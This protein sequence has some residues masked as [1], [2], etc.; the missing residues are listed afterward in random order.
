MLL[1]WWSLVAG[2]AATLLLIFFA[3]AGAGIAV[4]SD[5]R[6]VMGGV[7]PV[8]A[9][10]GVLLLIAD[11]FLPVPSSLIMA[12]NGALFGFGA[13]AALSMTGSVGSA[14]AAFAV[15]R[16]GN[17]AIRRFVTPRE[18]ERAGALLARWGL[19]AIALTRPV[20][21]LAETVAILAGSSPVTWRQ[22]TLAAAAGSVVPAAAYAWAGAYARDAVSPAVVFLGVLAVTAVMALAARLR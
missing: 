15:G 14:L 6:T 3:A 1:R 7:R 13:G 17:G 22:V 11:V 16:A 19:V 18:H 21:I 2:I 9:L 12:A 8:A 4:L 10:A 20:P 5:P